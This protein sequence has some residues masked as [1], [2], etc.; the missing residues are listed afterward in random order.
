VQLVLGSKFLAVL[1][2]NEVDIIH[3]EVSNCFVC[4]TVWG[5]LTL[6]AVG[7]AAEVLPSPLIAGQASI[8]ARHPLNAEWTLE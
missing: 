7:N 4:C 2:F 3:A 5:W 8:V 6:L 1:D